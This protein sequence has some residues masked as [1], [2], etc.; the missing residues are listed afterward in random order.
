MYVV[1]ADECK[2]MSHSEKNKLAAEKWSLQ[3]SDAKSKYSDTA[4]AMSSVNIS[5]LDENQ[6]KKL[7]ER[8]AEK[9]REDVCTLAVHKYLFSIIV[10]IVLYL[11]PF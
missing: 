8:H 3:D 7:I 9:L 11:A 4:K 1:I 10:R 5:S 2:G 6:K